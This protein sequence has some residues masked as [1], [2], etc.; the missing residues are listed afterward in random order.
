MVVYL[1]R[2][3]A[4]SDIELT[5]IVTGVTLT[6]AV[7]YAGTGFFVWYMLHLAESELDQPQPHSTSDEPEPDL[8]PTAVPESEPEQAAEIEE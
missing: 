4:G 2:Q 5:D 7:S 6:F 3:L 1:A 8:D